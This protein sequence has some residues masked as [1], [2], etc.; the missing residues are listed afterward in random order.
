MDGERA[1]ERIERILVVPD[2]LQDDAKA[3]QRTKVARLTGQHLVDVGDGAREVL[4]Q[5]EDGGA[6]VPRLQVIRPEIDDGVEQL[7]GE[8]VVLA[9]GGGPHTAH[10]QIGSIAR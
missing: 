1:P 7:D 9:L 10:Q 5:I 6:P 2:L 4:P 3:R 8:V